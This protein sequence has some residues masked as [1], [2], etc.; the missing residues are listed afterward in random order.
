MKNIYGFL[1][2][3]TGNFLSPEF[4]DSEIVQI[5]ELIL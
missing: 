1:V 2:D 5:D 3:E 4:T